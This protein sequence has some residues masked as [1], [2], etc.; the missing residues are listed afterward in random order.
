VIDYRDFVI[1]LVTSSEGE[2]FC[3]QHTAHDGIRH[4]HYGYQIC[5]PY[6]ILGLRA[7]SCN[8][9]LGRD[10]SVVLD[11]LPDAQGLSP[12]EVIFLTHALRR[13]TTRLHEA[14]PETCGAV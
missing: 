6:P 12:A 7:K 5:S 2:M 4:Q 1:R 3:V 8:G 14:A 10:P 13:G 9:G 11:H